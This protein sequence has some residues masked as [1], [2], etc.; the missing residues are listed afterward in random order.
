MQGCGFSE[1][2]LR[3]MCWK[4]GHQLIIRT[5]GGGG[6]FRRQ[7]LLGGRISLDGYLRRVYLIPGH[8]QPPS[9]SLSALLSSFL[10]VFASWLLWGEQHLFHTILPPWGFYLLIDIKVMILSSH[11]LSASKPWA[12]RALSSS[13]FLSS[14]VTATG[15]W[16]SHMLLTSPWELAKGRQHSRPVFTVHL[17][18]ELNMEVWHLSFPGFHQKLNECGVIFH[19][20]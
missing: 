8:F 2:V 7:A 19:H 9:L 4:L 12:K 5:L 18:R 15:C 6:N 11:G 1:M 13:V 14:F 3:G 16:L 10:S 20:L 17:E